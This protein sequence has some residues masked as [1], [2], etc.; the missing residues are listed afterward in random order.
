M[1]LHNSVHPAYHPSFPLVMV[2]APNRGQMQGQQNCLAFMDQKPPRPK[3]RCTIPR[4]QRK[5]SS[6]SPEEKAAGG[7]RGRHCLVDGNSV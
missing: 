4:R 3:G 5:S 6:C 1:S 2:K 7:R